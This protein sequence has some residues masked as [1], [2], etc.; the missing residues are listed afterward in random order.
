[1]FMWFA[2]FTLC[3]LYKTAE[4]SHCK[5]AAHT[6]THAHT[7]AHTHSHTHTHTHR[8]LGVT[9]IINEEDKV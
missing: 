4:I 6:H 3:S 1:M 8:S 7:H 9:K 2:G 5:A